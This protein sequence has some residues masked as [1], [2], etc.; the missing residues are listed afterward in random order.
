MLPLL[1]SRSL[2]HLIHHTAETNPDFVVAANTFLRSA[3][4]GSFPLFIS[5][6]LHSIGV[7]WG[8]SIFAFFACLLVP[9]PYL[10]YIFGKRIRARGAWSRDSTL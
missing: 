9:I 10:F 3:L 7:G 1:V 4:A 6:L 8:I 5:P 2:L